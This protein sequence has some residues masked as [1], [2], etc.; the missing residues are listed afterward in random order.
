MLPLQLPFISTFSTMFFFY[1]LNSLSFIEF[2][3][4]LHC[5]G[6]ILQKAS[7]RVLIN[8]PNSNLYVCHN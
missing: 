3:R 8:E 6:F 7:L 1:L 4:G 2:A 5:E